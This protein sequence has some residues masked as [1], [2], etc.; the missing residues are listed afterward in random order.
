MRK[1]CR[2]G[3]R[4]SVHMT[5]PVSWPICFYSVGLT[6]FCKLIVKFTV[7]SRLIASWQN[8][9]ST[10]RFRYVS[11]SVLNAPQ[12]V[13]GVERLF[14]LNQRKTQGYKQRRGEGGA[15]CLVQ[16]FE[17]AALSGCVPL[18]QWGGSGWN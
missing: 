11:V 12:G 10:G 8:K 3:G 4:Y 9:P 7:H 18:V 6:I 14:V 17:V 15:G 1:L 5:L 2:G 13:D 16:A